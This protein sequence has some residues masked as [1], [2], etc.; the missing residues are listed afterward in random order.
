MQTDRR[1]DFARHPKHPLPDRAQALGLGAQLLLAG[2]GARAALE[3]A[4]LGPIWPIQEARAGQHHIGGQPRAFAGLGVASALDDDR[5]PLAHP[6]ADRGA[7]RLP[8]FDWGIARRQPGI[9][10]EAAV[11]EGSIEIMVDRPHPAEPDLAA[12]RHGIGVE[13]AHLEQPAVVQQARAH[14]ERSRLDDQLEAHGANRQPNPRRRS[15]VTASGSP[16][17][18]DQLPLIARMKASA[19]P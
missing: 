13:Q 17:T 1:R 12:D 15:A 3:L 18:L 9:L 5:L 14:A 4:A 6:L 10:A 11:D 2:P 7:A 8:G 19:R 16:T